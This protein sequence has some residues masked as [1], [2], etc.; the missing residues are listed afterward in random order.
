MTHSL[1][2]RHFV[3]AA[4][5]TPFTG[6][7]L[8]ATTA[9]PAA[10]STVPANDL[11]NALAKLETAA[12]GRIGLSV[13]NTA[14]GQR[15]SYRAEERFPI[16]STFKTMAVAAILAKSMSDPALMGKR[17]PLNR[18]DIFKSGYAPIT[19]RHVDSGMTVNELCAATMQYSDNAAVNRLMKE[20]GGPAAVTNYVR[21]LGDKAFR[22]DRWE[23]E[24][25][26]AMP[27]DAR[28]TSTPAAMAQT[29]QKL[30]LG[31]ALAAPQRAQLIAWLQ[32]NTTGARRIR[33][34]VPK[35]WLVGDK[36]GTGAYGTTNDIGILWPTT[37][38]PI[39]VAIFFTQHQ[40]KAASR[41]DVIASVTDLLVDVIKHP[42]H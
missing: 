36:T 17:L 42:T 29:L 35:D 28:D 12:D 3:F 27:G 2:R 24:L 41:D 22:L 11:T 20:L 40:E 34:G 10:T 6:I 32:G 1:S 4:L 7:A 19:E 15:I 13:I 26:T 23:P 38:A 33:A 16:C 18:K 9:K 5:A 8:S 14:S 30:T 37:G 25:N 21:S 31:N 39:V